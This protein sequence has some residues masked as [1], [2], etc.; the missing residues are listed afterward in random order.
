VRKTKTLFPG[1]GTFI[2]LQVA[3]LLEDGLQVHVEAV[4]VAEQLQQV[5]GADGAARVVHQLPGARQAVGQDLKLLALEGKG[6][7]RSRNFYLSR[8]GYA[9][10]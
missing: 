4:A 3:H 8:A 9:G 6:E 5:A 1:C 2:L 7:S 10:K